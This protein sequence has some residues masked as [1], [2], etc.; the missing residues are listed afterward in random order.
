MDNITMDY[1]KQLYQLEKLYPKLYYKSGFPEIEYHPGPYNSLDAYTIIPQ[2]FDLKE[3]TNDGNANTRD[4]YIGIQIREYTA[5]IEKLGNYELLYKKIWMVYGKDMADQFLTDDILG[6]I[7]V[8]NSINIATKPYCFAYDFDKLVERGAY[9]TDIADRPAQHLDS[10]IQHVIEFVAVTCRETTG[11]VGMPSL[12][13][14]MWYFWNKDAQSRYTEDPKKYLE[15][16]IQMLVYKLNGS[17]MR[18]NESAFTNVSIMDESYLERFFGDRIFPNG[19]PVVA[20]IDEIIELEEF[21]LKCVNDILSNK[22]MTFPVITD[23]LLYDDN[24]KRF[25]NEKTARKFN[26]LNKQWNNA[27]IYCGADLSTLSSCCRVLNNVDDL[28]SKLRGFSNFIGGTDLNIGSVG[29]IALNLPHLA[30]EIGSSLTF[31]RF[32]S[33]KIKHICQYLHCVRL[34]IQ[35]L[36]NQKALKLYDKELASIER[37]FNTVGF[38]G[39]YDAVQILCAENILEMEEDILKTIKS[40]VEKFAESEEYSINI[41]QIPGESACVK[42]AEKDRILFGRMESP[43]PTCYS[44]QWIPLSEDVS[45]YERVKY[46]EK[47]DK[48]CGGGSILHLNLDAPF[49]SDETSWNILNKIAAEGVIYFAF[50]NKISVCEDEHG[51]YGDECWCGKPKVGEATRPVGFITMVKNW[52]PSRKKEYSERKW[53]KEEQL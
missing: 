44:N 30:E 35:D 23:C 21:F 5:P 19:E 36:I 28:D 34:C 11:A 4:R 12:F 47:L 51:F 27:N 41:E 9:F 15:Q 38:V 39:L 31:Q 29:V 2:S 7:Y 3:K 43:W 40:T 33:A 37:Q 14:Y 18:M 26:E 52:I 46:A 16:Q 20:H 24:N 45:L 53:M 6:R 10:F 17:E 25:V 49:Q 32:L 13:P 50:N 48:L 42:L 22:I 8:N 1:Y